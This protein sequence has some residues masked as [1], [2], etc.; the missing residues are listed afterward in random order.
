[1]NKKGIEWVQP[2]LILLFATL[3]ILSLALLSIESEKLDAVRP[4]LDEDL[5][6]QY[7][8]SFLISLLRSQADFEG[9]GRATIADL[10]I[11]GDGS[12]FEDEINRSINNI[13]SSLYYELTVEYHDGRR[14]IFV[15]EGEKILPNLHRGLMVHASTFLP[16]KQG[17]IKVTLSMPRRPHEQR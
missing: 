1:M 16:G 2:F 6:V 11:M 3:V 15:H 13:P 7:A 10:I 14:T 5:H 12:L 17:N 9:I 8:N 4:E